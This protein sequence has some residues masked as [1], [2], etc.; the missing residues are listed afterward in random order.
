MSSACAKFILGGEHSVVS[1]G[2]AIA[3][4]IPD[5]RLRFSNSSTNHDVVP[6]YEFILNGELRSEGER[7]LLEE[8]CRKL[9]IKNAP[10]CFHI[11][12]QI[13]IGSGLGSSA[14]L[15]VALTRNFFPELSPE[16]QAVVAYKGEELFHRRASGIDPFTIAL[17]RPIVFR[18]ADQSFRYLETSAFNKSPY[19][20]VLVDSGSTHNTK[21]VQDAVHQTRTLNPLIYEDLMTTLSSNVELMLP[22]FESANTRT[23]AGLMKDSHFRLIQ[24]G[25]SNDAINDLCAKLESYD[26]CLAAKITGAG[27]G[28][29]VLGLVEKNRLLEFRSSVKRDFGNDK[30]VIDCT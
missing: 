18:A 30:V 1:R 4:P 15:C 21:Q 17:D 8:L 29:F 22:A 16:E 25:V 5:L 28:G 27:C 14:A 20:F 23:L 24:L 11:D 6:R 3:F 19:C 12:S 13:P 7:L 2:R 10:W 9:G 26:S